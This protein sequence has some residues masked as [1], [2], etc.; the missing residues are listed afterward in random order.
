MI[1]KINTSQIQDILEITSSKQSKSTAASSSVGADVSL[2]ADYASL[3]ERATHNQ[4]T[5]TMTIQQT[6]KLVLSGQL[7][8][9][10]N[11]LAAAEE[12]VNFGV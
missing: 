10:E 9:Q 3:I 2:Q 6:R 1:E 5:N 8:S 4:Q 12:I 7:E 11:I